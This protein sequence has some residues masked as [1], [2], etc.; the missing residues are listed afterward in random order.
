M[1]KN[2]MVVAG[3]MSGTSA[4]GI[5][6][7]LVGIGESD[8]RGRVARGHTIK[9]LGHASHAYPRQVRAAVLAAMNATKASVADL[10][11]LNFLLG[12]LYAEALLATQRRLRVK[13]DLVGC[14]GQT[15]FHQGDAQSFLGRKVATTWQ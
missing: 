4:D 12:E 7:A 3:V 9:L 2:R 10:A 13:A 15:L 1:S 11:R 6:V 5:D 8:A 14:H